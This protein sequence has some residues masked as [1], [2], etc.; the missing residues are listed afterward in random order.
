VIS[1]RRAGRKECLFARIFVVA[2]VLA[3]LVAIPTVSGAQS[4]RGRPEASVRVTQRDFH[5]SAPKRLP[6]GDV[7]LR[8]KNRGP[9]D[10]ELLVVRTG[11]DELP[12]RKDGLTVDEEALEDHTAG[13]LEAG[14]PGSVRRLRLHLR[15]GHYELF[16][17]MSGHYLGGMEAE[18]VVGR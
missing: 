10:H 4:S 2:V 12:L 3:G 13:V 18:V 5:I 14:M 11:G 8:V 15:P 1:L 7:V 16:C 9:D 17:N 6:A